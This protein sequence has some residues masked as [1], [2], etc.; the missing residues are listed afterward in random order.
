MKCVIERSILQQHLGKIQGI[1]ERR[2]TNPLLAHIVLRGQK[3]SIDI[4]ATDLEIGVKVTIPAKVTEK[5]AICVA[6]RKLYDVVRE[7]PTEQV[8]LSQEANFWTAITAGKSS[9]RLPGL[10][11]DEFPALPVAKTEDVFRM[12]VLD[13]LEMMEKTAFAAATEESRLNLNGILMEKVSE[14]SQELLRMVATDG[15]RLAKIDRVV[16]TPLKKG[17]VLPRRGIMELRRVLGDGEQEVRVA[18]KDNNC[19]F[20]TDDIIVVL[21]LLEGEYPDYR[22]VIPTSQER[23]TVDIDRKELIGALRRAQ[24]IA[25][26]RAEGV[27]FTIKAGEVQVDAGG[28]DAGSMHEA[29]GVEYDGEP[30]LVTFNGRYLLDVLNILDSEKVRVH[31][32]GELAAGMVRPTDDESY[33]Y[34]IMPMR[35]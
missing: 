30:L 4:I 18:L 14:K 1:A 9:I 33:L 31:L 17:V 35:V 12:N 6:A 10:N 29:I 22:Q 32:R 15:H 26:E 3:D 27:R 2:T 24:V 21:R 19:M 23:T 25:A 28:Q 7:L 11:P 5:G 20:M 13:L 8:E 34:V 16:E